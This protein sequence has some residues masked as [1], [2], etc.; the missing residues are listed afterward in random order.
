MNYIIQGKTLT[1]IANAIREKTG[2]SELILAE[3]M[4]DEILSI[5]NAVVE[6]GGIDE[7]TLLMI[8]GDSLV[9]SSFNELPLNVTGVEITDEK[10]RY[11]KPVLKF[12]GLSYIS[13]QDP[14]FVLDGDYTIDWWEFRMSGGTFI[15]VN[16]FPGG[17]AGLV[18][19]GSSS[20]Y[21]SSNGT[22]WDIISD[23]RITSFPQN[24]WVHQAI[25]KKDNTL[26]IYLNGSKV[27]NGS[28]NGNMES[29]E[30]VVYIGSR[31]PNL[32]DIFTGYATEIRI[33][34]IA[35][36]TEDF[37]PPSAPYAK[38]GGSFND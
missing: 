19:I 2:K 17:Y 10:T 15:A 12:D 5:S 13:V 20:V 31:D 3:N 11:N 23:L 16:A 9:D 21:G 22:G 1:D 28:T 24:I 33:S 8:H 30:G 34:N 26:T 18:Y 35:R 32:G 14:M 4:A 29:G 25:V 27:I 36:W 38:K 37:T 6:E 7:N